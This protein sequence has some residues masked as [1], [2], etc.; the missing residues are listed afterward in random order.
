MAAIAQCDATR[1][2]GRGGAGREK[3]KKIDKRKT[4]DRNE[5]QPKTHPFP[6]LPNV[7]IA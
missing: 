2:E 5:M 1:P 7:S 4:L 6:V 3:R